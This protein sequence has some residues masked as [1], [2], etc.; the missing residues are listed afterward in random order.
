MQIHTLKP[1]VTREDAIS[2][3]T[4]RGA[5]RLVRTLTAGPLR[6]VAE[7]YVPFRVY[8]A[9]ISNRGRVDTSL[10]A[11]DSVTGMLDLFRFDHLPADG[12]TISLE[13]R[14]HVGVQ[15]KEVL[16]RERLIAKLRRVAYGRGF[17][18]LQNLA[19]TPELVSELY[20]PYWLG[21]RGSNGHARLAV[22]DAVRRRF[23]GAK[24]RRLVETWLLS[25]VHDPSLQ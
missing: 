10:V 3:F 19:I 25:E 7:L 6:S 18:R 4:A 2:Q 15:L 12:E 9:Q 16:A 20:L 21:F 5:T 8:R 24:M 14:N 23:E 1:N 13:T 22:I 17:F 11:I